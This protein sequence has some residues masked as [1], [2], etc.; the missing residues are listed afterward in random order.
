MERESTF[1]TGRSQ[2]KE[3]QIEKNQASER[4]PF[5]FLIQ[6]LG[7]THTNQMKNIPHLT[8]LN[9]HGMESEDLDTFMF[10]FDVLYG[11]YDYIMDR[12]KLKLFPARLNNLALWCF[13]GL[14]RDSIAN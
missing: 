4:I 9:F 10:E 7:A 1:Q 6:I 11:S 3:R 14:G 12:H 2:T 8:L 13:M 5:E